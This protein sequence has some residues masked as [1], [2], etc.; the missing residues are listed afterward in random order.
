MTTGGRF[1]GGGFGAKGAAEGIFV[2]S[3]L[4]SLTSRTN[5]ESYLELQ[6]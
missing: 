4:N 6:N 2:A 5:I 1:V 3:A